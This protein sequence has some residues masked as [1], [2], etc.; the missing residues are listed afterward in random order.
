MRLTLDALNLLKSP[1]LLNNIGATI[2]NCQ[3]NIFI[4]YGYYRPGTPSPRI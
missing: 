4:Y 2:I 1:S 3:K